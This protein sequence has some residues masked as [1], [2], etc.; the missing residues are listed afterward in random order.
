M[1]STDR[2]GGRPAARPRAA[3][4]IGGRR[5][6]SE[7]SI[8]CVCIFFVSIVFF[9]VQFLYLWFNPCIFSE[10]HQ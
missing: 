5:G 9:V 2:A 3:I 1:D 10:V 4:S 7:I 8:L 6:W